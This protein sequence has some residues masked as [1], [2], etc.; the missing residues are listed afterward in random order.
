MLQ[1][2]G[3]RDAW[4]AVRKVDSVRATRTAAAWFDL[5]YP[6]FKRLALF[7][8]S[9]EGSIASEQWVE[10]ILADDGWWL[11][12]LDTQRKVLRLFVLQGDR[13]APAIQERLEFAILAGPPRKM[14]LDDLEPSQWKELVDHRVWLRLAKLNTSGLTLN[15]TSAS[16]LA[17]LSR[18][19]PERQV[20]ANESDEFSS[21]MSGT[22][23][24]DYEE[25]R[26][27]DIAPRK[28]YEL[29]RWLV[30]PQPERPFFYEDTWRDVCRTRFFHSFY[31]LCDLSREGVWPAGRWR[32]ALQ[33]WVD[34][35][36]AMRSW[37]FAA[38]LVQSRPDAV[39]QEIS[40]GLTWWLQS[41]SK[42]IDRH[43]ALLIQ[44]CE[45]VLSLQLDEDSAIRRRDGEPIQRP[46]TEAI[47]HPV[48][49]VTQALINLGFKGVPNDGEGLPSHVRSVF[50]QLCDIRAQRFRHGRVL[51]ASRLIAFFRVDCGW[52]E[53]Y[54]LPLFDWTSDA[55]EARFAWEGFLWSPRLYQP[56][57]LAF[58]SE[59]LETARHY[60]EL[61]EHARQ[62]AAFLTFASLGPTDGFTIQEW[63]DAFAALPREGLEESAQALTQSLEGAADQREQH[64]KNRIWPFWRDVWPKTRDLVTP[65]IA[66]SLARMCIAA[67]SEFPAALAALISWLRPVG[68]P[69]FVIR[70]LRES[71]LFVL[72]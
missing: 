5:P 65:A 55:G 2:D 8:A 10:W 1:A 3:L 71:G 16:R 58:K 30:K 11:W 50:T 70:L 23:D 26:Y 51:L 19:H 64:W 62:F 47:N 24:P 69:S 28:R 38:P 22:G 48:G 34:D 44:M 15:S 13:L 46:V 6:T 59:F 56:R 43:E 42:S 4:L 66:E 39:M 63:R 54:L 53:Q 33:A 67:G 25:Q 60:R 21:W 27:V 41:V 20:R 9:Q 61:G 14:Y 37:H 32:E 35:G 17:E 31:A 49:H 45:R 29:T 36:V 7:A 72:I 18:R 12:A 57:L 40:H 68:R 52:T